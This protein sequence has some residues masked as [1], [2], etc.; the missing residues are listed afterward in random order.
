MA[1]E[2]VALPAVLPGGAL[3]PAAALGAEARVHAAAV[4]TRVGVG[5]VE[6]RQAL[7]LGL[8]WEKRVE[9]NN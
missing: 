7:G 4:L 6:V 2:A 3:G 5:A 1:G 8:D 9:R